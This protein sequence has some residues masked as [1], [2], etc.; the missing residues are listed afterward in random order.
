MLNM[1]PKLACDSSSLILLVKAGI[2]GHVLKEYQIIITKI[3]Y[4]ETVERGK[5]KGTR[6]AY[7]IEKYIQN[8]DIIIEEPSDENKK[9]IEKLCDLHFGERDV[10]A[11]ALEK[12][13]KVLCDDKKGRNSCKVLGLSTATSLNVLNFLYKKKKLKKSEALDALSK[14]EQYGW[15]KKELIEHVKRK[16]EG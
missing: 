8:S 5:A 15:Y 11:L 9:R 12:R 14:L 2:I 16:I 3:I 10:T 7:V 1:Y 6:D 13:I 4:Q